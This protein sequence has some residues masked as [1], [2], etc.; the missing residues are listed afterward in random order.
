[1]LHILASGYN[2]NNLRA[3]VIYNFTAH[4]TLILHTSLLLYKN[5]QE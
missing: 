1:M 5:I 3:N 4:N 2:A